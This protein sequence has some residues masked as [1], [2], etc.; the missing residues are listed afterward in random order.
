M[1]NSKLFHMLDFP[2]EVTEA[3]EAYGKSRVLQIPKDIKENLFKRVC[4]E[5]A[6]VELKELLG[7]D[8][9]G[10]KILWELLHLVCKHTYAQYQKKGISD[11]IFVATMKFCTRYL[12][13]HYRNFGM[14]CFTMAWW[15]PRELAFLEFRVGE[16]EYEFVQGTEREIHIHIPSDADLRKASVVASIRA[17]YEFRSKYFAE[18]EEVRLVCDSWLL[19]PVLKEFLDETSNILAFQDMF[20]L[21]VINTE[22]TWFM[23]FVFPGHSEVTENLPER[24]SLQRK[25]KAHLLEGK[26]VGVAKGHLK[27]I[28]E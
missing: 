8:E 9:Y 22:A 10:Y 27:E 26:P 17:F 23:S 6:V 2:V 4:W 28:K 13:E 18:W 20:E 24:T 3:L 5:A 12:E 25:M 21:D 16:L 15:F 19:A 7:E 11:E 1:D 14:Y